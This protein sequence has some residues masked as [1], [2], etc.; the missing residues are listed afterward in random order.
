MFDALTKLYE[1]KNINRK[2]TLTN[3]LKNVKN[4]DP[5]TIQSYFSRVS[6]IK[7]QLEAIWRECWRRDSNDHIKWSSEI[8]GLFHPWN[9]RQKETY[10]V[11]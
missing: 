6:Q 3:Q 1:E 7:E 5:E 8:M 2:M 4:Q 9:M 11:Q 10:Q